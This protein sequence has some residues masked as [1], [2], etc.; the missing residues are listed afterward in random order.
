MDDSIAWK[1][2]QWIPK[3]QVHLDLNDWGVLQG[4]V[5]VDRLRTVNLALL[6]LPQHLRRLESNCR[7]IGIEIDIARIRHI[8]ETCAARNLASY[9]GAD[10]S[11]VVLVTPGIAGANPSDQRGDRNTTIVHTQA[12]KWSALAHWYKRGQSILLATNRNVPAA[13]WSPQLKTRARLQYYL[14]DQFALHSEIPFAGAI[15][16][17]TD[18]FLT[19]TSAANLILVM[20]NSELVVAPASATLAGISL[21][22][23]LRLA[24][25]AQLKITRRAIAL[26]D[27]AVAREVLLT[28]T[29]GCLWPVDRLADFQFTKPADG[30]IYQLLRDNWCTSIAFDYVEQAL[31]LA[32]GQVPEA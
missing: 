1:N 15:L 25:D 8:V 11:V 22:R 28:G 19:E 6:D 2:G 24:G 17:D 31:Q 21:A 12:I 27:V 14:A 9:G 32:N 30:E 18:G 20:G 13:C 26:E 23:T 4:V 16:M 29:T 3:D 7:D 5:I 10:F